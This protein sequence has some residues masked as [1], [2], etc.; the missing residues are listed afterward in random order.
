MAGHAGRAG[1]TTNGARLI[2]ID[3][4]NA[5]ALKDAARSLA[6]ANRRHHAGISS[7]G[8]SGIFD[9]L[10][11][12][13][14]EDAGAPSARTLLL[15]YA[16]DL[17]FRVRWEIGPALEEGRY[18]IA[19]PYVATAMALGQATGL[20]TEWLAD[21]FQFAPPASEHHGFDPAPARTLAERD[22][23]VEFAARHLELR[24][25]G[26]TR[27]ELMNRTRR[28]LRAMTTPPPSTVSG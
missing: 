25:G 10:S 24:L 7:W 20:D 17:A 27:L 14:S 21:L 3:G 5:H 26:L 19:A 9:E 6:A 13:D 22:G 8:A 16:A 4:V 2:A 15:L 12:A 18:V 28:H 1:V 11:V 23:F